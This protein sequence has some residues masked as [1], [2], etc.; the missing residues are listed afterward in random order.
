MIDL[1]KYKDCKKFWLKKDNINQNYKGVIDLCSEKELISLAKRINR[2]FGI[3]DWKEE[4]EEDKA[5]FIGNPQK[6]CMK[7]Y[8]HDF[9]DY[10][11]PL[12]SPKAFDKFKKD[13]KIN[14]KK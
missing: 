3:P 1:I 14:K 9:P 4:M 12:C 7:P 5:K 8:I 13:S 11:C 2:M 6:M 10:P